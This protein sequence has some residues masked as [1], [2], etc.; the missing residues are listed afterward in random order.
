MRAVVVLNTI[1]PSDPKIRQ[2]KLEPFKA[3]LLTHYR[4]D[5]LMAYLNALH[6]RHPV[7]INKAAITALFAPQG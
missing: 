6:I 1:T 3:Q 2:E 5:L 4:D 7:K